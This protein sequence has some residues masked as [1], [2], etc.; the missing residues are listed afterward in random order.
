MRR[1]G[2]IFVL[3]GLVLALIAGAGV[4]V[5]LGTATPEQAPAR[6]VNV[7]MAVQAITARGEVAPEQ[8]QAVPWPEAIPTPIGAMSDP[9]DAIGQLALVPVPPGQPVTED[10]LITKQDNEKNHGY[11]SMLIE[12]GSVGIAFPVSVSTNV[13]DAVQAGDRVDI[14]ATFTAEPTA[15]QTAQAA[16]APPTITQR[17][18]ADVLVINVGTWPPP[19]NKT[20]APAGP[21]T[22]VTFQ[23]TEQDALVLQ[24]AMQKA[25]T[26]NLVLRSSNDHELWELEP[27]TVD[28]INKRFGFQLPA[29]AQ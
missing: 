7:V 28:Y 3:L 22:I 4:Y 12:K 13:A 2:R 27:V 16:A 25:D 8:V 20:G 19:S 23:L 21:S 15:G 18:L 17:M 10:M 14:L 5:V 6:S 29:A 26:L 1:G 9:T 11:A 24:H